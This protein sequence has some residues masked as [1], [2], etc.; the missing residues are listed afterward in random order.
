MVA[1]K[2]RSHKKREESHKK[3]GEAPILEPQTG[4]AALILIVVVFALLILASDFKIDYQE[5]EQ[6]NDYSNESGSATI[7]RLNAGDISCEQCIKDCVRALAQSEEKCL[8]R[9]QKDKLC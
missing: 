6:I 9:C 3:R 7:R 8:V 1:N 5:Q 4:L 2:L